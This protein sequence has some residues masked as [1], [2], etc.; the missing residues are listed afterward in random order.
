VQAFPVQRSPQ[1][2][3][4]R[5]VADTELL[6]DVGGHAV[7]RRRRGGQ[8]GNALGEVGKQ[9][10]QAAVVR[11]EVVAPVGNTVRL[12]DHEQ[13][14]RRRELGEHGVPEVGVVQPFGTDEQD[15]DLAGRDRRLHL[16]PV[17]RVRGV[18]G[19]GLDPGALGRRDLVAH[20]RQQRRDDHGRTGSELAEQCRGEEVHGRLAPPGALHD[21][22]SPPMRH[23]R[24]DRRP[25]V[26]AKDGRFAGQ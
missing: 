4:A 16:V 20:Q 26:F 10:A 18:H 9:G 13:P 1:D 22:G 23:Q 21:E 17:L 5:A 24:L 3:R 19:R 11:P 12:V 7:V 15:V 25:L 14:G 2:E 8:D 6:G